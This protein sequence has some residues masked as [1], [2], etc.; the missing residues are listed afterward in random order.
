MV[1]NSRMSHVCGKGSGRDKVA[2][3]I[4]EG[5]ETKALHCDEEAWTKSL[6]KQ[7]LSVSQ[8]MLQKTIM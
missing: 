7:G 5:A 6:E 3:M 2:V 8:E 4:D 1:A